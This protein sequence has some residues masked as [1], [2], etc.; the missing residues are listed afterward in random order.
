MLGQ[1]TRAD[2]VGCDDYTLNFGGLVNLAHRKRRYR[3]VYR[4]IYWDIYRDKYWDKS[5]E[6]DCN[7][8]P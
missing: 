4:N 1:E 2:A 3:D 8:L 6:F 5:W 7:T